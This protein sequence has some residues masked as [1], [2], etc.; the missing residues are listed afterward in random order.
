MI[1]PR[2]VADLVDFTW[3]IGGPQG[4]GVET[5]S[6]I[7]SR[8]CAKAGYQI[9]GKREF[10]SNI[11]GEHSYFEVRVSDKTVRSNSSAVDLMVSYDAETIFRHYSTVAPGGS[12][13][14][15][16]DMR[17]TETVDV[18]TMDPYFK[19][20]LH[21][22][23]RRLGVP[24][25]VRGV[26]D[27]AARS[28]VRTYPVSF[29]DLLADLAEQHGNPRLK[30]MKRMYNVLGVS[31]SAGLVGL[32]RDLLLGSVQDVFSKKAMV[33]KLNADAA[34]HAY[35]S[36]ADLG[37][38][39]HALA[40]A[41]KLPGTALVQGHQGTAIGK[42]VA[43]CRF[44]SYYPI[45][46]ASDESVYLESN[47]ILDVKHAGPGSISV[48]Q[49]EDEI[50]AIGMMIGAALTGVRSS[51]STSG[52]GFSLM[53]EAL[54]WA[55]INEVPVVITLYQRSGPSTGLPTRHGQDDLL[56][57]VF[58]GHGEFPRI[59][60][61]SGDIEESFYDTCLCFNYSDVYQLPVIHMMDKFLSSTTVTCPVFDPSRITIDR[62][63][64]LDSIDGEYRRFQL[65]GDGISPRSYLGLKDGIF[66]NTG[67]ESDETGHITEDPVVRRQMM[68]KRLSRMDIVLERVP[69]E[70]QAVCHR[71]GEYTIVSWGSTKGPILDA[72]EMLESEGVSV[73]FIQIKML[74]PFP[75]RRVERLLEGAR[76]VIDVESNQ[77]GQMGKLFSQ[78]IFR[79][80]DHYILKYTG[81]GMTCDELHDAISDIIRG[82]AP[83]RTVLMHGS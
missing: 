11:K 51:T 26:L 5:A 34:A 14:Y 7:F 39:A 24:P 65:G 69:E 50:S 2:G 32:P 71:T 48:V 42:M 18:A 38:L 13:I 56:F 23:I 57:A 70:E 22:E 75:A 77:T 19:E 78:S 28:G 41:G 31:L 10:H 40:G 76:V 64:L 20:R 45:T 74:H 66:W 8:V 52:P 35:D 30:L 79:R 27:A 37:D 58:G 25:T 53:A 4:S 21:A 44:Q 55:G 46:P 60:Y 54:G 47:E 16:L 63:R 67:D 68:D 62:G 83:H 73:G 29:R 82:G 43:G 49:T 6:T 61:A 33:K 81:R 3:L 1:L 12:I 72:L 59:V 15:D 17:D 80:I 9:F 36:G